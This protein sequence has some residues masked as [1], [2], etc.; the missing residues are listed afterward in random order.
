MV[1]LI[2]I[3]LSQAGGQVP[4]REY[5]SKHR[6]ADR[7]FELAKTKIDQKQFQQ[8]LALLNRSL[9]YQTDHIEV[10]FNRAIV[11]EYLDD[12]AGAFTDYQ[13]VLLLD[14][15]FREAAFNKAKLRYRE[16][17]YQRAI[18]DFNKVLTMGSSGTQVIYFKGTPL[19]KEGAVAIQQVT[20][21]YHLDADIYN[22]LGLCYQGLGDH[23]AA[24]IA[25]KQAIQLNNKD[26]NY[27][28]NKGL[29]HVSM[30][31]SELAIADFK[32]ALSLEPDHPIAQF[33]LTQQLEMAGNLEITTY[34]Q[35]I[36]NNPEFASAYVN[37]AMAKVKNHDLQGAIADYDKA[38]NIDPNDADLYVNRAL[39]FEKVSEWRKSL[40][41]LNQAVLLDPKNAK[42]LRSRGR[43]LFQ[44]GQHDLALDDLNEAIS[45]DPANGGSYFNRALIERKAG[46]LKNTCKDLE[47]ALSLG[48]ES[49]EKALEEYCAQQ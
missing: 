5:A 15:T 11:K 41:D 48:V 44:L 1:L 16:K 8:A 38:I 24:I 36:E 29:S 39:A 14:S 47:K 42:A 25:W 35:L 19:N 46:N 45:L 33:N 31:S 7:L 23:A 43:I 4:P 13:I 32:F 28:V 3:G 40:A 18:Y 37:R 12:V 6:E 10:Y 34:D 26:A 21:S 17:Q 30:D 27:Y 20:T 9:Q 49:A 22:Y 2:F